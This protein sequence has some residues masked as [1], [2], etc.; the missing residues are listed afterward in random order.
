MIF[1]DLCEWQ[2]IKRRE[3]CTRYNQN[4]AVLHQDGSIGVSTPNA[5]FTKRSIRQNLR[6]A[7][8]W[9]S[10]IAQNYANQRAP[11][12]NARVVLEN[13][14]EKDSTHLEEMPE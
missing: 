13:R 1:M 14:G 2:P 10:A 9:N 5:A 8:A 6:A 12:E 11:G 3:I 4:P 7:L